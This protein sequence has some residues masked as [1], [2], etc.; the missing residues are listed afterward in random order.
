M[1]CLRTFSDLPHVLHWS[2]RW[3]VLRTSVAD[4]AGCRL[5]R[6]F[7]HLSFHLHALVHG[8]PQ[9]VFGLVLASFPNCNL[10]GGDFNNEPTCVQTLFNNW[11]KQ[12][13]WGKSTQK[14]NNHG[15]PGCCTRVRRDLFC[16]I[17]SKL[18]T[19]KGFWWNFFF[20]TVLQHWRCVAS[21][22]YD[23]VSVATDTMGNYNCAKKV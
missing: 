3:N 9:P 6:G 4:V 11:T 12:T 15:A 16:T 5:R 2:R 19:I 7:F 14:G 10:L 13:A 17:A 18:W 1:K 8:K 22:D 21:F 20:F 23:S